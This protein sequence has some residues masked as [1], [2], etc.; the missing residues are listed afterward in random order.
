V[1]DVGRNL[2]L[3]V[4]ALAGGLGGLLLRR[5]RP[6]E[7]APAPDPRAEELRQR[8]ATARA[9]AP[10]SVAGS[11]SAEPAPELTGPPPDEFDAMRRRVHA[12]GR[13]AAEEMRRSADDA[14]KSD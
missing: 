9:A 5:R 8:L 13:A 12:E 4:G 7:L 1:S 6:P 14:G 2:A 11:S 3:F 10:E